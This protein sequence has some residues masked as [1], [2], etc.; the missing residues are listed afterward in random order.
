MPF[1][2]GN[3]FGK[4]SALSREERANALQ[5]RKMLLATV[6]DLTL[7]E[8]K[9]LFSRKPLEF[10]SLVMRYIPVEQIYSDEDED[11]KHVVFEIRTVD[12]DGK[13]ITWKDGKKFVEGKEVVEGEQELTPYEKQRQEAMK[14]MVTMTLSCDD[15]DGKGPWRVGCKGPGN[16]HVN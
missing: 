11:S 13:R 2:R 1:Q 4:G 12:K 10:L 15:P 7:P 6:K 9:K 5:L 8:L 14:N 16:G 3:Q